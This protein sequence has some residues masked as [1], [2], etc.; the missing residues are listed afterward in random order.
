MA[1]VSLRSFDA[2]EPLRRGL[3]TPLDFELEAL[4]DLDAARLLDDAELLAALRAPRL[5]PPE[6]RC[7]VLG[8]EPL[9]L[10]RP[11]MRRPVAVSSAST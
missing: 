7:A 1:R 11:D 3:L 2:D 4:Q 5:A 10:A 8:D 6:E 9:V